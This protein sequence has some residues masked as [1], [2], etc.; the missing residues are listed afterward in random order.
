MDVSSL[1][2]IGGA[3]VRT[4]PHCYRIN[5][6]PHDEWCPDCGKVDDSKAKGGGS[7]GG[8]SGGP[9]DP[10][11]PPPIIEPGPGGEAIDAQFNEVPQSPALPAPQKSIEHQRRLDTFAD[12]FRRARGALVKNEPRKLPGR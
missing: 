4:C 12:A 7:S 5:S 9:G 10:N 8:G 11:V 1:H 2:S 6:E 3:G